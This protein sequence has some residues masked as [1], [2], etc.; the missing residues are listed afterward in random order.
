MIKDTINW[1]HLKDSDDP[2]ENLLNQ[3]DLFSKQSRR[4]KSLNKRVS[5]R[6][7]EVLGKTKTIR[8]VK[9]KKLVNDI[10]S[11]LSLN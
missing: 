11:N 2:T 10:K 6:F 4:L 7:V 9:Y 8:K 5:T 3:K 1:G